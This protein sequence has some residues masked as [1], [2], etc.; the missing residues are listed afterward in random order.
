M[1]GA[2]SCIQIAVI[3][4][5]SATDGEI[6]AAEEIGG[7]L[8][9]HGAILISGGLG[10]VMEASC[11][12]AKK[13][14]GITVGILPHTGSGNP[15]LTVQVR[16]GLS[17]ARN[18][19]VVESADSVVAVGGAH[20]TLSEIAI[21]LKTGKPVFG[22]RSW[23]IGGVEPCTTPADAALRALDAARR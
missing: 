20:G 16:T 4:P 10:G 17:H 6:R 3:G 1:T 18:I 9:E 14:G 15:H 5:S 8:A 22:Y 7:I 12:G 11:R 2:G 23:D 19:V 21:A 13:K